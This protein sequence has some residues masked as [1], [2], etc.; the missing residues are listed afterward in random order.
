MFQIQTNPPSIVQYSKTMEPSKTIWFCSTTT[1]EEK[2]VKSFFEEVS[3][4]CRDT[5]KDLKKKYP[6]L[7]K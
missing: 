7:L 2:I 5:I 1:D 6:L 3:K 4:I